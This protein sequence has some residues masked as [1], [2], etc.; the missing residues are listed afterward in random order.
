MSLIRLIEQQIRLIMT[1]WAILESK[2][3]ENEKAKTR[4]NELL[5]ENTKLEKK[6]EHPPTYAGVLKAPMG[7]QLRTQPVDN[8]KQ[9][10]EVVLIKPIDENENAN[11][12]EIKV[13]V[14]KA[15][16]KVKNK[17]KVKKADE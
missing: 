12:D 5:L 13:K 3:I 15:L 9:K 6:M 11:N 10:I 16:E 17:L 2:L 1:K 4:I 14:I 7:V 8:L